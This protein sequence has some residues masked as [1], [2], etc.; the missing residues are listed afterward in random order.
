VKDGDKVVFKTR[1]WIWYG[2]VSS[3]KTHLDCV[4]KDKDGVPQWNQSNGQI[5]IYD[6]DHGWQLATADCNCVEP[7]F[8]GLWY[9][10]WLQDDENPPTTKDIPELRHEPIP[11]EIVGYAVVKY[12]PNGLKFMAKFETLKEAEEFSLL[13]QCHITPI[14][15]FIPSPDALSISYWNIQKV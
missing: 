3:S 13:K 2:I 11:E 10:T 14:T 1:K 8:C 7:H 6:G 12:V 5:D 4:E 15:N 9:P